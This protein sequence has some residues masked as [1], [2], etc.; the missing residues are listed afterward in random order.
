MVDAP[1]TTAHPCSSLFVS[2]SHPPPPMPALP[3]T[4]ASPRPIPW[5]ETPVTATPA[6]SRVQLSEVMAALSHALDLTEGQ[7]VGHSIRSCLI[8][9]RIARELGLTPQ[10]R[11][12]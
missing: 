10:D 7:P 4:A 3:Q 1:A 5:L 11:S 9:M 2:M 8:A 6:S 12:A